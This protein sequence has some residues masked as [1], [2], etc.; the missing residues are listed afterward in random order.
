M[1]IERMTMEDI[2]TSLYGERWTKEDLEALEITVKQVIE[3]DR[4]RRYQ[5]RVRN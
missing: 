3:E 2:I 1:K 5:Q 4:K